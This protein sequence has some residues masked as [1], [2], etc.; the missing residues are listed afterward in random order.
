MSCSDAA[1]SNAPVKCDQI[2][3]LEEAVFPS[4]IGSSDT[5]QNFHT[6]VQHSYIIMSQLTT[7]EGPKLLQDKSMSQIISETFNERKREIMSNMF[8]E[9]TMTSACDGTCTRTYPLPLKRTVQYVFIMI[10]LTWGV[11]DADYYD[12]DSALTEVFKILLD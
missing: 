3:W 9:C 6:K 12:Q 4:L 11:S 7:K 8:S 5:I 1:K 10:M 2:D